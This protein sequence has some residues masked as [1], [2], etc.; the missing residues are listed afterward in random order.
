MYPRGAGGPGCAPA[1]ATF[2]QLDSEGQ[3][4][5]TESHWFSW[6]HS[7]QFPTPLECGCS[8]TG[9]RLHRPQSCGLF[10]FPPSLPSSPGTERL[11]GPSV[12]RD[13][14][15]VKPEQES[16]PPDRVG[17]AACGPPQTSSR[18]SKNSNCLLNLNPQVQSWCEVLCID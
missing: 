3:L 17:A 6:G 11:P 16:S 18:A 10:R 5:G 8:N 7:P 2:H 9:S 12:G 14:L 13:I 15:E 1:L 4:L